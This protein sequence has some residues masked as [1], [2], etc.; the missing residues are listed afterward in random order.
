MQYERLSDF[1]GKGSYL[2]FSFPLYTKIKI[3]SSIETKNE[4]EIL[5]YNEEGVPDTLNHIY[6][7]ENK[8]FRFLKNMFMEEKNFFY[9]CPFCNKELPI[10]YKGQELKI[11]YQDPILTTYTFMYSMTEEYEDYEESASEDYAKRINEFNNHVLGDKRVL[12]MNLECTSKYKH[13][14]YTIFQITDDNKLMKTGQYPSILDF[15]N[16][17]KEYKKVLKDKNITKE[18]TNAE[19]LK[20]HNMGV[21]AFL[22]LRRIFEKL[23]FETFEQAKLENNID[24]LA[25]KIAKT[26]TKVKMLFENGYVS[27]YLAEINTFV[28]G[29]LSKGIHELSED[30]CNLHYDTLREAILLIL[31]EKVEMEQKEKLKKATKKELNKIHTKLSE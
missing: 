31:E 8:D 27:R 30:E 11:E 21:G 13:K 23:I 3:D 17:L 1:S 4:T 9:Y 29:I 19:I 22:Y 5:G 14:L 24:E 2:L 18:L 20:T 6:F 15:D 16:S 10:I 25:F 26:E 12:Q 7:L 28:Y